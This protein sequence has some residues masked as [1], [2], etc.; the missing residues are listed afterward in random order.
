MGAT[1]GVK[2][3]GGATTFWVSVPVAG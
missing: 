2:S 3:G 1:I